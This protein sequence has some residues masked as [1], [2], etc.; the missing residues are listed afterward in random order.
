[1]EHYPYFEAGQGL[2][3]YN[4]DLNAQ[5]NVIADRYTGANPKL[6]YKERRVFA[7]GLNNADINLSTCFDKGTDG[8][9]IVCGYIYSHTAKT[10]TL[11]AECYA[12]VRIYANGVEIFRSHFYDE[13]N[14]TKASVFDYEMEK[15]IT[16]FLLVCRRTAAGFGVRF[17][18]PATVRMPFKAR[19]EMAG[20]VYSG[21]IPSVDGEL[22]NRVM[23]L[24][25][26]HGD[27]QETGLTW[28]PEPERDKTLTRHF[29]EGGY[30]SKDWVFSGATAF[31][32]WDYP[33]GVTLQGLLRS[34]RKEYVHAHVNQCV[35][36]YALA[37][38]ESNRYG[39]PAFLLNML[40]H[41]TLDDFGSMGA[42]MLECAK[43]S[44]AEKY[45]PLADMFCNI[46]K[47]LESSKFKK[48]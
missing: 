35:D 33:V 44:T 47:N 37:E 8:Y 21:I 26:V 5:I 40:R 32:R 46:V 30:S 36:G 43:D 25:K 41:S 13:F 29:F 4:A 34:G 20:W 10:V 15:G 48:E 24:T 38:R 12:P 23:G 22:I 19:M 14:D 3:F 39:Q 6:A 1:M 18:L 31:G 17:A 7:N 2:A 28:Y 16:V 42:V 9:S 45:R 27:E 11:S